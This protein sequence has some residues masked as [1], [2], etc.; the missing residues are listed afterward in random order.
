M[1]RKMQLA[2]INSATVTLVSTTF[3]E[4]AAAINACAPAEAF[5]FYRVTVDIS[6]ADQGTRTRTGTRTQFLHLQEE[7]DR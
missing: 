3:Q 4:R 5:S 1:F 6:Y 7:P 2:R